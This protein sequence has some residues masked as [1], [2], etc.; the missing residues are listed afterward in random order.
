[1]EPS[2]HKLSQLYDLPETFPEI[3]TL[4]KRPSENTEVV[5]NDLFTFN[6]RSLRDRIDLFD[7]RLINNKSSQQL[8]LDF[9]YLTRQIEDRLVHQER[10]YPRL[11]SINFLANPGATFKQEGP[12][13]YQDLLQTLVDYDY[14]P[15][16]STELVTESV[17]EKLIS[18]KTANQLAQQQ[19]ALTENFLRRGDLVAL[20]IGSKVFY[21]YVDQQKLL[22]PLFKRKG[23]YFL[24]MKAIPFLRD[25]E[26]DDIDKVRHF[27]QL[28]NEGWIEGLSDG[29][30]F[31]EFAAANDKN[32]Q[33]KDIGGYPFRIINQ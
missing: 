22:I 6:T 23:G 20:V 12:I 10:K 9:D 29:K 26:L 8:I 28:R 32:S 25:N 4:L 19:I 14:Q 13:S 16:P 30:Q 17:D 33:L 2:V 3:I 27:Y 18:S 1:M 21:Y 5:L 15:K 11:F 24:P 7:Q 31:F